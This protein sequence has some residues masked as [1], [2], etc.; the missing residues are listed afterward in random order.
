MSATRVAAILPPPRAQGRKADRCDRPDTTLSKCTCNGQEY[1]F[2]NIQPSNGNSYFSGPDANNEYMFYFQMTG[3][4]L[5][6]DDGSMR[7]CTFGAGTNTGNAVGLG[8]IYGDSCF[9]IGLVAQQSWEIDTSTNRQVITVT[10]SGGQDGRQT[11][12]SVMCDPSADIPRFTVKGETRTLV[13][14]IF[15]IS[16]YACAK[17]PSPPPPPPPK[18]KFA[19]NQ[20]S[21]TCHNAT[22]GYNSPTECSKGCAKPPPPPPPPPPPGYRCLD[23]GCVLAGPHAAGIDLKICNSICGL[24]ANQ[25]YECTAGKCTPTSKPEGL[26][27]TQ[28][29]Q[30]CHEEDEKPA[31]SFLDYFVL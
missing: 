2:S 24:P 26:N 17:G 27:L 22:I 19:C 3:G 21:W 4:G 23:N 7:Y 8:E 31:W 6:S 12:L 20:T 10:F 1:D 9:P 30:F 13:Y 15:V 16:K 29:R 14:E 18:T 5:P 11:I 28:C 25:P